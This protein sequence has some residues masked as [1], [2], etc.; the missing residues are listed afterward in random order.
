MCQSAS[1]SSGSGPFASFTGRLEPSA[2]AARIALTATAIPVRLAPPPSVAAAS[3]QVAFILPPAQS[4]VRPQLVP[5]L[6][7]VPLPPRAEA[8]RPLAAALRVALP[9]SRERLLRPA[10]TRQAAALRP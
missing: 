1:A 10:L 6:Q 2:F 9:P 8:F 5:T 4:S 3:R 7:Q